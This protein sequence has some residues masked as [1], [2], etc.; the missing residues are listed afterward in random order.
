[1]VQSVECPTLGFGSGRDPPV[2]E[3]EPHAGLGACLG[4]CASFSLLLPRLGARALSVSLKIN[5]NKNKKEQA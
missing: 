2:C 1:M 3:I 5:K 4:F